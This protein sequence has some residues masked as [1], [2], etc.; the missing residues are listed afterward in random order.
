MKNKFSWAVSYI[1]PKFIII[2]IER[3]TLLC[4]K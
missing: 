3:G 2:N 4:Y 1:S